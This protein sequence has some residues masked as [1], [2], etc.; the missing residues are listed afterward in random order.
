MATEDQARTAY[1]VA[2]LFLGAT[3]KEA[4]LPAVI[5]LGWGMC[6]SEMAC[7]APGKEFH[8]IVMGLRKEDGPRLLVTSYDPEPNALILYPVDEMISFCPLKDFKPEQA[9]SLNARLRDCIKP[10]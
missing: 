9:I 4:S 5:A 7:S 10:K 3:E 2:D 6:V 8:S 1:H